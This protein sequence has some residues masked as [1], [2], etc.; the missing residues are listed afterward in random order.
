MKV[1]GN[2]QPYDLES[3]VVQNGVRMRLINPNF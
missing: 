1:V 3:K 2:F